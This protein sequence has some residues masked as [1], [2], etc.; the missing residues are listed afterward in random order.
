MLDAAVTTIGHVAAALGAGPALMLGLIL[1]L[2]VAAAT[3]VLTWHGMRGTNPGQA[4]AMLLKLVELVLPRR[5]TAD[6]L[7]EMVDEPVVPERGLLSVPDEVWDLAVRRAGVI[8]PLTAAG[9]VGGA[10]V[11]AT[12]VEMGLSRRPSRRAQEY[13]Q[14]QP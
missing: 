14:D 10:A 12:A 7:T 6:P 9:V 8:G 13:G 11:E 5:L 3:V 2:P 4:A 1:L